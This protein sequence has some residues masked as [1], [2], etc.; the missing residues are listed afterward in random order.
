MPSRLNSALKLALLALLLLQTA[1][2][3]ATWQWNGRTH[4]E[5]HWRQIRTEHFRIIYHQ[6][7]EDVARDGAALAEA[8]YQPLLD[9]IQAPHLGTIDIVFT[10]E[11]EIM[12]GFARPDRRIVIWVNQN[13]AAGWFTG[14][15]KW[16]EFVL[17]HEIQHVVLM[18]GLKTWLGIWNLFMVPIW[19]MEGMA[20]YYTESWHVG[21]SDRALKVHTYRDRLGDLG[22]HDAGYAKV[23]YLADRFGDSSLVRMVH[24]RDTLKLGPLKVPKPYSFKK[25]LKAATGLTRKAFDAQWRQ[26][27]QTYYFSVLGQYES[28]TETGQPLPLPEMT[29]LRGLAISP[30]TT[31]IALIGRRHPAMGD[32]GLYV[33]ARDSTRQLDEVHFGT[34]GQRRSASNSPAWSPDGRLL[35]VSE[36]HRG[37]HGSLLW[38]I[39]LI[40]LGTG[41]ARW[42]TQNARAHDP[43]W[44]P[45]GSQL[46]YVAHPGRATNLYLTTSAGGPARQLTTFTGDIQIQDPR[47][48]PDG[49]RIAFAVQT[50]EG[51]VNIA[52]VDSNGGGYRQITS[53]RQT[54]LLPLWEPD[55]QGLIFT[56]FRQGT[57]N[58]YRI[59]L[60]GGEAEAMSAVAEG[61]YGVQILAGTAEIL[62]M[63]PDVDS[64][65]VRRISLEQRAEPVELLLRQRYSRWRDRAVDG[66]FLVM[67]PLNP[68]G[69]SRPEPYRW[70][71][72]W[73]PLFRG[74]LPLLPDIAAFGMWSDA[75]GKQQLLAQL[76]FRLGSGEWNG[77]AIWIN[78]SHAPLLTLSA[79]RNAVW[80]IRGYGNG[81]LV[82]AI[83][84]LEAGAQLPLNL[85]H[86]LAANHTFAAAL[87]LRSRSPISVP[88][89]PGPLGP[90]EEVREG[91]WTLGYRWK[92]QRPD[93][94]NRTLPRQGMGAGLRWDH[95]SS[96]LYGDRDYGHLE[97]DLF[98]HN[99]LGSS[100]LVIFSRWVATA[101]YGEPP[102]Q[103]R[104]GLQ[105]AGP[106]LLHPG[107]GNVLVGSF[108]ETV[109]LHSLRGLRS[110]VLG[111]QVAHGT[112]ELRLPVIGRLP[113]N[114][115]GFQLRGLTLALFADYGAVW[116]AGGMSFSVATFGGELK[117]NLT[118]GGLPLV[119]L[120]VG[121]AGQ[122]SDWEAGSPRF[123]LRL[124]MIEPF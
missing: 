25:A 30:D 65:R 68:E 112:H 106:F 88:D 89:P 114:L 70:W 39:R 75:L 37:Q 47:W 9:Q 40:D 76:D 73:K 71:R 44:S 33:L 21:R 46:L 118:L 120:A 54:D 23:L 43:V 66:V 115:A 2:A 96:R 123:Y 94:R 50:L 80:R 45:D 38:D 1:R 58:L 4:P 6:G 55:G 105:D 108:L 59:S 5:L 35:A 100:P 77:L 36:Y 84:A 57:P 117:A 81:V 20:E 24:H 60:N 85:G 29:A 113:V 62:A 41:Q 49:S 82:E 69:V 31:R 97:V 109:E 101:Q 121:E 52:V 11:D 15:R 98:S 64:V 26:T 7:L 12:N 16:L 27:M 14:N 119:T 124:G 72:T 95:F 99:A 110:T 92:Y 83:S 19:F 10:A 93:R 8:A 34:L 48:S 78:A 90:P 67:E 17:A 87:R 18:A 63:T 74:V 51:E 102:G 3:Q 13:D 107:L 86:R 79:Y 104:I 56:S 103:D 122:Q 53:G 111:T 116:Q 61:L 28:V 22:S 32:W 91:G 42:L